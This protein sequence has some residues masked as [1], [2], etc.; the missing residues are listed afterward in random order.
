[1]TH[2]TA[3]WYQLAGARNRY[4]KPVNVSQALALSAKT[5]TSEYA[6]VTPQQS[7]NH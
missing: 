1:M 5:Q 4:R 2:A 3:F 6:P 7:I